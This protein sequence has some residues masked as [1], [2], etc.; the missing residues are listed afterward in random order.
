[1]WLSVRG[2]AGGV[3]ECTWW[4]RIGDSQPATYQ[5]AI[6]SAISTN[7]SLNVLCLFQHGG[8][9]LHT[10]PAGPRPHPK[11][12]PL[13]ASGLGHQHTPRSLVLTHHTRVT[14]VTAELLQ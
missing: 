6:G 12:H 10:A 8:G 13:S 5:N 3:A 11:K 7:T 9:S 14:R 2:K 1:M 4:A